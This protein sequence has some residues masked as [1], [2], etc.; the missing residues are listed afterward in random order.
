MWLDS[1]KK[2]GVLVVINPTFCSFSVCEQLEEI[3]RCCSKRR[4]HRMQWDAIKLWNNK[5]NYCLSKNE[6][7]RGVELFMCFQMSHR[8]KTMTMRQ[9]IRH[10][11]TYRWVL[12]YHVAFLLIMHLNQDCIFTLEMAYGLKFRIDRVIKFVSPT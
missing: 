12:I 8:G 2:M 6:I 9:S 4:N 1:I 7:A 3:W 11:L 10:I 5:I